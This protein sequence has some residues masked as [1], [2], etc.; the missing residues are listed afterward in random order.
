MVIQWLSFSSRYNNNNN[1][2]NNN[3]NKNKIITII[4]K[5]LSK[6][7]LMVADFYNIPIGTVKKIGA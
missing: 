6:Y 2:N 5:M 1:N 7:Q 4:I 3:K